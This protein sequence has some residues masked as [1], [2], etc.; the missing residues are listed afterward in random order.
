MVILINGSINSGKSTVAQILAKKI[1]RPALVE[2]DRLHEF[3]EWMPIDK[4]VP[5]NIKTQQ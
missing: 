5:L 1:N 4:A 3:I 2:V